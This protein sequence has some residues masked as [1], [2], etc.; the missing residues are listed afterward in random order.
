MMER[1]SVSHSI[2]A[3]ILIFILLRVTGPRSKFYFESAF[4]PWL[5][6]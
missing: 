2:K 4:H 6:K 3:T 1:G 5:L